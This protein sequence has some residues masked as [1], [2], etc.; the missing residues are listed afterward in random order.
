MRTVRNTSGGH[1]EASTRS[2]ATH[3]R[4]QP[5]CDANP[6]PPG[7]D[8]CP[9]IRCLSEFVPSSSPA[10]PEFVPLERYGMTPLQPRAGSMPVQLC[11]RVRCLSNFVRED[12]FVQLSIARRASKRQLAP[13]R[14]LSDFPVRL[15]FRL[16]FFA[17][18]KLEVPLGRAER[19]T[20]GWASVQA[21][22]RLDACP[23]PSICRPGCSTPTAPSNDLAG[24]YPLGVCR[25]SETDRLCWRASTTRAR[26]GREARR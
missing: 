11:R 17:P 13:T 2:Q 18:S 8:A 20:A 5:G 14:C 26:R 22:W 1:S 21:E 12:E 4:E 19:G 6:I 7:F 10:S 3:A 9:R 23:C 15:P 16:P 25:P 24:R